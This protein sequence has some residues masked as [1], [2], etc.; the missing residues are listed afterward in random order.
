MLTRRALLSGLGVLMLAPGAL[1]ESS[2]S[3][4]E[5]EELLRK[6]SPTGWRV[7]NGYRN[8]GTQFGSV[9]I[10]RVELGYLADGPRARLL[11]TTDIYVHETCHVYSMSRPRAID[12][13]HDGLCVFPDPT[14]EIVV[15]E[16]ETFPARESKRA[17]PEF[18]RARYRF[19]GYVDNPND[20]HA[21][22][23]SGI[24]GLLNEL[25]AYNCGFTS[26]LEL[27]GYLAREPARHRRFWGEYLT[28]PQG[29]MD[30]AQE[31]RGF[32]LAYL[33]YARQAHPA[34]YREVLANQEFVRAYRKLQT[35]FPRQVEAYLAAL[36]G[37]ARRL[38][39][40]IEGERLSLG[41]RLFVL[42]GAGYLELQSQLDACKP[43]RAVEA[44][45][46]PGRRAGS[47]GRT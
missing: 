27:L 8:Q 1:A 26:Q 12:W 24:F 21:T 44:K 4:A 29:T 13:K 34:V 17:C 43:L 41:D 36:P 37:L 18:L 9:T 19:T 10:P 2:T 3:Q 16:S 15:R 45:L 46:Q 23:Q 42:T 25:N 20:T 31:F 28:A 40:R 5:L 47:P 35:V 32:I 33:D 11:L 38:G 7:V 39:G 14:S 22:Q 30:A 6:G